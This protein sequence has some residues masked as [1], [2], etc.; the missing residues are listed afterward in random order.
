MIFY[1]TTI[2]KQI[3]ILMRDALGEHL[4]TSDIASQ[5]DEPVFRVRA[6]LQDLCRY[7]LVRQDTSRRRLEWA[8]TDQGESFA[9]GSAQTEL[10]A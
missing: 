6:E 2:K 3:L 7:R 10:D 4:G 8:L 9:W 1:L 5:L